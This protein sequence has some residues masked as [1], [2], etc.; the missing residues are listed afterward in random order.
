MSDLRYRCRV[1][2]SDVVWEIHS[3]LMQLDRDFPSSR[4]KPCTLRR[5]QYMFLYRGLHA[6]GLWRHS[7]YEVCVRFDLY[8]IPFL[9]RCLSRRFTPLQ[10]IVKCLLESPDCMA[11]G[12]VIALAV[13]T[14][15]AHG[16]LESAGD[17]K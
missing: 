14:H 4:A 16:L 3:A 6:D 13:D 8:C 15:I 9:H 7:K 2:A 12:V 17:L 1:I 10:T 11:D 5:I